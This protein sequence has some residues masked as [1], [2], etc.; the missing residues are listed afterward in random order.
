MNIQQYIELYKNGT[1]QITKDVSYNLTDV[2]EDNFL[3]I[4]A[5][6]KEPNFSDGAEKEYFDP[7]RIMANR[8]KSA[9]DIDTKDLQISAENQKT[10]GLSALLKGVIKYRMK[11]EDYGTLFNEV[12]DELVDMG[13][14]I[15]KKIEGSTRT[16]D[17]RNIIRPPHIL[18][19]QQSGIVERTFLTWDEMLQNKSD[20]KKN[21]KDIEELKEKM[22]AEGKHLFTV[23]EH[24]TYDDFKIEGKEKFTKG[25]I[26]YLD[27]SLYSPE[28][29]A[30]WSPYL[31]LDR[32]ASPYKEKIRSKSRLK[33]LRKEGYLASNED[34]EPV[35]PYDEA[36]FITLKG[37]WMGAGCYE[38]LRSLGKAYRR[39]MNN[40]IRFD[41][42]N[43]KGIAVH[44]KSNT[45]GKGLT[46]EA[47][48]A[49]Q[50]GGVVGIKEGERLERLNFGS[51]IGE[52]LASADKFMEL[53]RMTLGITAQM[54][55][56]EMPASQSATAAAIDQNIA[57]TTFDMIIETQALLWKRYFAK[58]ELASIM[59]D[60]TLNEWSKIE[61]DQ[62]ELEELEEPFIENLV[63]ESVASAAQNGAFAPQGSTMPPEEM[64]RIKEAVKIT[65]R[66][67]QNTRFAQIKKDIVKDAD[68]FI[69]F[70]V[71]NESFDKINKIRELQALKQEAI[72]NPNSS[73]SAERL[74]EE[75]LDLLNL[76][77]NRFKKTPQEIQAQQVAMQQAQQQEAMQ[78][79]GMPNTS[80]NEL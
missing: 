46:Q 30:D 48:Q 38:V 44:T 42:I 34:E 60:I 5:K 47:L 70:Y 51:M 24:W 1:V 63:N 11:V 41:E 64:D 77:G 33:K 8:L 62:I 19:I 45:K 28:E 7:E 54:T 20:W 43:H 75:I 3:A 74:E 71:N 79:G 58:F 25:C 40:K 52:F 39:N 69:E 50:Y 4:N 73:L 66:T 61:G 59:E 10:I 76:S 21:W 18:D 55:G 22:K 78:L 15:I 12:R 27:R 68:F 49:L 53:A 65:R 14:V 80:I 29:V 9:S 26:K 32:F 35:Y 17:L 72:Q 31:E 36:R 23:Y 6:Y 67:S 57:K 37:R 13:H 16:V 56:E 2:I